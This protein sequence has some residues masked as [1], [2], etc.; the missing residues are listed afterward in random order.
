VFNQCVLRL[1][2]AVGRFVSLRV[3]VL[4]ASGLATVGMAWAM[5]V[6]GLAVEVKPQLSFQNPSLTVSATERPFVVQATAI[7]SQGAVAYSSSQTGVATVNG[8]TGLVTLTGTPGEASIT[9]TQQPWAPFPSATATLQLLVLGTDP[10]LNWPPLEFAWQSAEVTIPPPTSANA[11]APFTYEVVE[12]TPAGVVTLVAPDKLRLQRAGRFTLRAKQAAAGV[13]GPAE[14][15]TT[16]TVKAV[17]PGQLT[18]PSAVS[19]PWTDAWIALPQPLARA[20]GSGALSYSVVGGADVVA[21][22]DSPAGGVTPAS[23]ARLKPSKAG[24]VRVRVVQAGDAQYQEAETSFNVEITKADPQLSWPSWSTASAAYAP[25]LV[26]RLPGAMAATGAGPVTYSVSDSQVAQVEANAQG[27]LD[28]RVFAVGTVQVQATHEDTLTH[29]RAVVQRSF[30]VTPA[31]TRLQAP[32]DLVV[33]WSPQEIDLP[34]P[35]TSSNGSLSYALA[36]PSDVAEVLSPMGAGSPWRLRLHKAGAVA[37]KIAQAGDALHAP[38]ETQFQVVVNALPVTLAFTDS[39]NRVV[40]GGV[41]PQGLAYPSVAISTSNGDP[42]NRPVFSSS[43]PSVLEVDASTGQLTA[44]AAGSALI[45]A[46]QAA[47]GG[48]AAGFAWKEV[49]VVAPSLSVESAWVAG[50]APSAAQSIQRTVC[51]YGVTTVSLNIRVNA[52]LVPYI[53]PTAEGGSSNQVGAVNADGSFTVSFSVDMPPDLRTSVNHTLT[54]RYGIATL[55]VPVRFDP[56]TIGCA[57]SV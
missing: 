38:A 17:S 4:W 56:T 43:N 15:V 22:F 57:S 50:E 23:P 51:P 37:V 49:T 41:L 46:N 1:S 40:A 13:Y 18:P 11:Q 53:L 8:Q 12:Q 9:A 19:T 6:E 20:Q 26:V 29:A 27:G 3:W 5:G 33:T 25:D 44:L 45:R 34:W 28:L 7:G 35:S 48:H 16:V 14:S 42:A 54:V 30:T 24:T 31:T 39:V 47:L 32:A 2:R 21:Q 55:S 36:Q 10:G 52:G